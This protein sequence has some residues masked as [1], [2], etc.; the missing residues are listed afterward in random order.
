[1]RVRAGQYWLPFL[2][3]AY[4]E[5]IYPNGDV[6]CARDRRDR[7]GHADAAQVRA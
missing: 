2:P 4:F 7:H 3:D 1:M 6:Q 5:V